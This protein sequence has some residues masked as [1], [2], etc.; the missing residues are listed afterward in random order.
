MKKIKAINIPPHITKGNDGRYILDSYSKVIEFIL[1]T[2]ND[3]AIQLSDCVLIPS[4]DI[5]AFD[6]SDLYKCASEKGLAERIGISDK[7]QNS[8]IISKR[9]ICNNCVLKKAML[10]NIEFE[11]YVGFENSI[12]EDIHFTNSIFT[13]SLGISTSQV[14]GYVSCERIFAK[15]IF[16]HNMTYNGADSNFTYSQI[17]SISMLSS[18]L[19]YDEETLL[20][21]QEKPNLILSDFNF[22]YSHLDEV[23]ISHLKTELYLWFLNACITNNVLIT[24]CSFT[25]GL[26]FEGCIIRGKQSIIQSN[27]LTRTSQI[28][29]I[30]LNGCKLDSDLLIFGV[31]CDCMEAQDCRVA[32]SGRLSIFHSNINYIYFERASIYGELNINHINAN[33]KLQTKDSCVINMECAINLGN[34]NIRLNNISVVNYDTAKIL[35]LAS[36]K[37]NNSIEVTILKAIEHKL[38]FEEY[39]FKFSYTSISDYLLLWLNKV[40]NNF[41]TNWLAGCIFC[42]VISIIFLGLIGLS[43]D[44][45]SFCMPPTQWV[46]F[47]KEY[48]IKTFEFLW[49][50]YLD[51]FNNMISNPKCTAWSVLFYIVGKSLIAY[52][53]FQT[54]VAFRKYCNK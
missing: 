12:L 20:E 25:K 43:M 26:I 39:K 21:A 8:F 30:R 45:Y 3:D 51:S 31:L 33:S 38:Y 11:K 42:L 2:L 28:K 13:G 35:R 27:D 44:E 22:A 24:N 29:T 19:K 9:I 50:P 40:S 54:I 6:I 36:Q 16:L 17:K 47:T 14:F 46:I 4:S 18:T 52:G 41:G 48:W 5:V 15:S 23:H 10:C 34:I 37:L 49:L 1:C 32:T 53:I 7:G